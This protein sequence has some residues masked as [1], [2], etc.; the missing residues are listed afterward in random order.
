MRP[1]ILGFIAV[2]AACIAP[3]VRCAPTCEDAS[4]RTVRCGTPG[5]MPVGWTASLE[6]RLNRPPTGPRDPT[7][8]ELGGVGALIVLLIALIA[9][10]PDFDGWN[11]AD[12]EKE[13]G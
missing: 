7:P 10:M 11:P 5:A 8:L 6:T 12:E 3:S 13:D 2:L 4:G 1:A 9:L